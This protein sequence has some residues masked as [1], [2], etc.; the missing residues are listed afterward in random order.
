[1]KFLLVLFSV[2]LFAVLKLATAEFRLCAYE[3]NKKDAL[4]SCSENNF[5]EISD[6]PGRYKY[7]LTSKP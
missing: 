2:T 5:Y 7:G 1:M 4:R 3:M 6:C